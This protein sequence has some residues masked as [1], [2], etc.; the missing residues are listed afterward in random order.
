MKL[1]LA[2]MQP[3][4]VGAGHCEDVQIENCGSDTSYVWLIKKRL[5]CSILKNSEKCD[6]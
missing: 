3:R 6:K 1:I 4:M 2:A 5:D